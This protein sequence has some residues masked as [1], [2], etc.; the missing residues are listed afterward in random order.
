MDHRKQV[1]DVYVEGGQYRLSPID[2]DGLRQRTPYLERV[3]RRYFPKD[4]SACILDLGCGH[5]AF[6]HCIRRAG[7]TN[8]VGIDISPEQVAEAQRLGIEGVYQGDLLNSLQQLQSETQDVVI[9]FDVIEHFTKDELLVLG[10]EVHR[11]LKQ[12]GKWIIHTPNGE[13]LFGS[14]SYF[15]DLTH[16]TGFT[17]N[18]IT[19]FL[20]VVG[21]TQVACY[22]DKIVVHGWKSAL[23]FVIWE[24]V[25]FALRV[26]LA[27]ETGNFSNDYILTQNFLTVATK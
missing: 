8:V 5:G 17:R 14:R 19:Q 13:G 15:G 9:T 20:K 11:V 1:Y 18:S 4:L 23:R 2:L 16:Q 26:V 22:E 10:R 25:R 27:A 6:I 7:Y 21:F 3:I 24:V 12:G